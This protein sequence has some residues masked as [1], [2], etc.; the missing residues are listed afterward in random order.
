[1]H[2]LC[3]DAKGG[4]IHGEHV[5][6]G[7]NLVCPRLNV[8]GFGGILLTGYFDA[9]LYLTQCYGTEVN[10][11]IGQRFKPGNHRSV[12]ANL[13]QFRNDIGVKKIHSAPYATVAERRLAFPREGIL[14]SAR[15][16][17]ESS[18]DLSDG[19]A[20]LLNR[21]HSVMG[22]RTAVST[23]RRETSCGPSLIQASSNSLK[24]DFA[25]CTGQVFM[26]AP[27]LTSQVTSLV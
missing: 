16:K 20:A 12:G 11:F 9:S 25:S 15:P 22:I 14:K 1:M 18:N 19:R 24:R 2:Q 26:V 7:G 10:I 4:R 27:H 17:S 3:P 13:A 6:S 5:I 21:F 8:C 23:P